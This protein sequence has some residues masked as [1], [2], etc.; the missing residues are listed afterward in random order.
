VPESIEV[1]PDGQLVAAVLM[2]GSNLDATN[3]LHSNH[4]EIAL[5]ARRGRTFE[6]VQVIKTGRI[7][8]GVAF[9]S[10]GRYLVVQAHPEEALWIY[11]VQGGKLKDTGERISVPGF[12][13][14]LRA[15]P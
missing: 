3:P 4:G 5:L 14:S 12:P 13:S 15:A 6:R 9:T 7:P 10:D 2:A 1:S 8:E 11:E